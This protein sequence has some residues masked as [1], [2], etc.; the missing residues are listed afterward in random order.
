MQRK[1][2]VQQITEGVIWKQLLIFFFPILLG[3]F[4]QQMYNTVDTIIVG[5]FVGTTALAAVGSTGPLISLINGFFIGMSSGVTV[6][7]SQFY[8]ANDHTGIEKGIHTGITLSLILGAL[9]TVIGIFA[10]PYIL[11]LIGTPESCL[12]DAL[13]YTRI[14]Y[15]G[16]IATMV[17]NMGASI[18]RAMGD[19]KRPMIFLIITCL[20]NIVMDFV[21]VV[22][23]KMGVSGAAIATVISQIVSALLVLWVMVRL[24]GTSRL[25]FTKLRID[26]SLMRNILEIGI[27]A[28]LQ[29]ITFDLSN[30]LIQ[31]GIN[32]FGDIT[33]AAWTA[34]SKTEA[35]VWMISSAFGVAITTFVGQNFGAEKY[36]R[37]RK[38]IWICMGMAVTLIGALCALLLSCKDFILSIYTTDLDVIRLGGQVMSWIEPFIVVFVPVEVFAGAMRGTGYSIVPT[39][40]TFVFVCLFRV[41]WV[42]FIVSRWHMIQ[43]LALVYPVSWFLAAVFF[44]I[45]YFRGTWLRKSIARYGMTP[46]YKD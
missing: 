42:I 2:A 21:F 26:F 30:V 29:F 9:V 4:F 38:S 32:S 27:P 5:R 1:N 35:I 8:G 43:V 13:R 33:V 6:I 14:Y 39:A 28:G 46:E 23:L 15:T 10:G 22:G 17:Y 12:Q 37:I 18:L 45:T 11:K 16:A 34:Y 41:L 7:L 19:S 24:P 36:K 3:T 44:F 40:I 25:H 31:S 20:V